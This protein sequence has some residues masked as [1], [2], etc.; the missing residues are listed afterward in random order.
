MGGFRMLELIY[1]VQNYLA[2][3]GS[4]INNIM[5]LFFALISLMLFGY[6]WESKNDSN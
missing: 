6:L 3:E 2:N 5:A 1:S 4:S